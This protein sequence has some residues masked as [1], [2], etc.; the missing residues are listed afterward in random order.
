MTKPNV[1]P[2][3]NKASPVISIFHGQGFSNSSSLSVR[4]LSASQ[5]PKGRCGEATES[6]CGVLPNF[7][8][9]DYQHLPHIEDSPTH[10]SSHVKICQPRKGQRIVV[11][12]PQNQHVCAT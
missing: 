8:G 10:P 9:L 3:R 1:K 11:A 12:K 5:I 7:S 6:A 2:T 4:D